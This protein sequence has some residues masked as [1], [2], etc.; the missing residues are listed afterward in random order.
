MKQAKEEIGALIRNLRK[1]RGLSQMRLAEMIEVS[2]QQLQK[3]EKGT[4]K[5]SVDRL[6]QLAKALKVPVTVFF[7]A[8]DDLAAESA[9]VYGMLPDDER[10]LLELYRGLHN[11]RRKKAVIEL[12]KA[13][14]SQFG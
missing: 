2:Y 4:D 11:L 9:Q 5:V 8:G 12:L 1:A 14:A 6:Q 3:Y 13:M 7:P 10:L